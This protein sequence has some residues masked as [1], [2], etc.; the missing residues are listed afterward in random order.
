MP[1]KYITDTDDLSRVI[2]YEN[3]LI[4]TKPIQEQFNFATFVHLADRW[5]ALG[6]RQRAA[7]L[8][9]ARGSMDTA[10]DL[11]GPK[12]FNAEDFREDNPNPAREEIEQLVFDI[13]YT[14]INVED[15]RLPRCEVQK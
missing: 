6:Q 3:E 4:G 13:E 14:C 8:A 5:A 1:G 7:A 9:M 15:P 10:T 12:F 11:I 2:S